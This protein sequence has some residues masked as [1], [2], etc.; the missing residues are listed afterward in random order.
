MTKLLY[1]LIDSRA[2]ILAAEK[3]TNNLDD[4]DLDWERYILLSSFS[5]VEICHHASIN[6]YGNYCVVSEDNIIKW[7]WH[8][9]TESFWKVT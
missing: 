2:G 6:D 1:H 3:G 4:I 9:E 8:K 7:E 5:P